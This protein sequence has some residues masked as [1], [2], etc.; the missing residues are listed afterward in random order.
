MDV[1]VR[2]LKNGALALFVLVV[3]ALIWKG[4]SET[5]DFEPRRDPPTPAPA[6]ADADPALLERLKF[7]ISIRPLLKIANSTA[8]VEA[9]AAGD[10]LVIETPPNECDATSLRD[11]RKG[12]A[13][14]VDPASLG[15]ARMRCD[16]DGA[17]I[18]LR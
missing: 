13:P 12:V 8:R 2:H 3:V 10:D 7:A 4:H 17:V 15:F 6:V 14:I 1:N 9:S 16:P 11:L 5:A 18:D